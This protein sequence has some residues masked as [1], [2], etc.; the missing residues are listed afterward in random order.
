MKLKSKSEMSKLLWSFTIPV[1]LLVSLI[2]VAYLIHGIVDA[3]NN[4]KHTKKLLIE[5][6]GSSYKRFGENFKNMSGFS[7]ELLHLFNP[8][9]TKA[10]LSGDPLPLYR[11]TKHIMT[12]ASPAE[13]LAI[14][15]DGKIVDSI[16]PS[17][18]TVD[19][20]KL[21][22]SVP[23]NGYVMLGSFGDRKGSFLDFFTPVD[24]TKL[25][26][27]TKFV[28]STIINLTDQV[29][30]VDRYFQDQK[31]D[32]VISLIIAGIIALIL[33]GLLSTFWLR[34]L[35]NKYI[36]KPVQELNTMAEDIAAGT[37]QGEVVVDE[38]SDFAALQGL[39]K[40]GQLILHKLYENMGDKS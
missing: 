9:I 23:A 16:N 33:F 32:T 13:Y 6:A 4:A 18:A 27:Q 17:G 26:L 34:Y 28:A 14:I 3:D 7:P 38:N 36:R 12:L 20:S 31:R 1:L 19:T 22:T 21:P 35:I 5:Q 37:Y 29:K 39:L 2:V 40:S 10:I 11:L 8:D 30:E 25:G 15:T 24:M